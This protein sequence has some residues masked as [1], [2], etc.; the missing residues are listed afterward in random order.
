MTWRLADTEQS[1]ADRF[2]EQA[3]LHPS[4]PALAGTSWEPTFAELDAAAD[5]LARTVLAQCGAGARVALLLRH[6]GALFAAALGALRAGATVVAL[7]WTD[8]PARLERIR[9]EVDPDIVLSDEAHAALARRAGFGPAEIVTV[10]E[11]PDHT[12]GAA[13]DVDVDP[14]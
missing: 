9:A 6:D 7:N 12:A 3:R 5:H 14:D 4:K 2:A 1:I 13:P 10:A 8:P 11:Q